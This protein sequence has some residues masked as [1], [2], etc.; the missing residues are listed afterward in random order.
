M[1]MGNIA[2]VAQQSNHGSKMQKKKKILPQRPEAS[3]HQQTFD[4][5]KASYLTAH[6]QVRYGLTFYMVSQMV[7]NSWHVG[8]VSE[9]VIVPR[10]QM[11]KMKS[12]KLFGRKK[13]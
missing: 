8:S 12:R 7:Q 5:Q 2:Y 4:S 10:N 13:E 9:K 3:L 11:H 1:N 6:F